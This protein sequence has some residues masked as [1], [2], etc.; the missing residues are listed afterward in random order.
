M[1]NH[2][3]RVGI[4]RVVDAC[5]LAVAPDAIGQCDEHPPGVS[6]MD[7]RKRQGDQVAFQRMRARKRGVPR[8]IDQG[9]ESGTDL[10]RPSPIEPELEVDRHHLATRIAISMILSEFGCDHADIIR[11]SAK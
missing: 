7:L 1:G 3:S 10:L 2:L 9:N 4:A 11:T 8:R 5:H 6:G